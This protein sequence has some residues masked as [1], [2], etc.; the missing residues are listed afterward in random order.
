MSGLFTTYEL[1]QVQRKFKTLPAFFLQWFNRQIN[2]EEDA[3]AFD[4]VSVNYQDLAPFVAPNVQGRVLKEEGFNRVAF[5][6]P[7]V[8]PKHVVDPN[9]IIPVQPGETPATGQLSIAQRRQAVITHL[10]RKQ[11]AMHE[12]RWEWMACQA[13][14]YGYVDVEGEDYPKVRVDFQR[15]AALTITTDW[16]AVDAN[17]MEDIKAARVLANDK[18]MSGAVVRDWIFGG[19]SWAKFWEIHK[20]ELVKLMDTQIR[21]SETSVTRLWDGLEGVEYMGEIKGLNGAG[22]IRI[23]VN[24]QKFRD[25]NKQQV[26]LF[27]QNAVLGVSSAVD[28]VRC[29]GAIM[30]KRAGYQALPYFPKN[31]ESEDPSTEYLM[32][33]GAPLMVPADPNSTVLILPT[34]E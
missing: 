3:I 10:L 23:W 5:K 21:G 19:D 12:N 16:T 7:Y 17:P 9:M 30:D 11:K 14:T 4:K 18:S 32:S 1:L 2:F 24:T 25:E 20:E 26:Y 33:Q 28:G 6:P 34:L 13:L 22:L 8:K 31:W 15:D 27:P 29:F